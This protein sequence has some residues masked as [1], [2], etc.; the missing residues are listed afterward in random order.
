VAR[1]LD[2]ARTSP[3]KFYQFWL[4]VDDRDAIAYLKSFTFLERADIKV[5]EDALVAAPERREAQRRL[6]HE[7]T[8]FV[9]GEEPTRRAEHASSVV[10]G[11]DI[12]ELAVSD[13][14]SV[15][16]DVPS[17]ALA[18]SE[19]G[20]GI[21]IVDLLARVSLAP[22]KSEA[23]RLVQGGGVYVNNRRAADPHERITRE[24]AIGGELFVIRKGQKDTHLI[25]LT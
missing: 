22:S 2:P 1:R 15:F 4:N 8:R 11:G 5:L 16:E 17:T 9:H 13:V 24:D 25:R 3:F 7:V 14:L 18:A 10:F 23:R 12:T 6:A 21:A 20:G 19:L